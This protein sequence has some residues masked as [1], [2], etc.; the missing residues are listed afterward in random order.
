MGST[1]ALRRVTA[2]LAVGTAM[3]AAQPVLADTTTYTATYGTPINTGNLN[4]L[5]GSTIDLIGSLISGSAG[6]FRYTLFDAFGNEVWKA[7]AGIVDGIVNPVTAHYNVLA[8]GIYSFSAYALTANTSVT[9]SIN[10]VAVPGP[11][12]AAGLPG[13]LALMGYAAWRRRKTLAA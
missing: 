2:A 10:A 8:S 7:A 4:L 9:A 13:V 6:G 11:V 3:M 12:A 1:K 5:A